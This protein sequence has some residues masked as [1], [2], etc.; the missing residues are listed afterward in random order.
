[1]ESRVHPQT[2]E[3]QGKFQNNVSRFSILDKKLCTVDLRNNDKL[4]PDS[5]IKKNNYLKSF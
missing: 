3:H 2:A 5:L 4:K 1:M